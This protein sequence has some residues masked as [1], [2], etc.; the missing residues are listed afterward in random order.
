[1]AL[2]GLSSQGPEPLRHDSEAAAVELLASELG[3]RKIDDV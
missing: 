2:A 1:M 3:A